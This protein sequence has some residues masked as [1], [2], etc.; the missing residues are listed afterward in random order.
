MQYEF[1]LISPDYVTL[2]HQ[3]FIIVIVYSSVVLWL[4]LF[5]LRIS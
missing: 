4:L 5:V 3:Q 1:S 2:V